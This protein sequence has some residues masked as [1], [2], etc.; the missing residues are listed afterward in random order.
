M[1]YIMQFKQL[2]EKIIGDFQSFRGPIEKRN[3]LAHSLES[4]TEEDL[5]E[6]ETSSREL[7]ETLERLMKK[8]YENLSRGNIFNI[9]ELINENI[10]KEMN[11]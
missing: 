11:R 10:I 8:L 3:E 7:C 6:I 4:A 1:I 5:S 9:Y 2:D